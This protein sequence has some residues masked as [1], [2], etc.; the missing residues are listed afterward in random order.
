MQTENNS[1]NCLNSQS[2]ATLKIWLVCASKLKMPAIVFLRHFYNPYNPY[3]ALVRFSYC[4]SYNHNRV[5]ADRSGIYVYIDSTDMYIA[6]TFIYALLDQTFA[7]V[8]L[9]H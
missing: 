8:F 2:L 1:K 9:L 3:V 7:N 6:I 4:K 5:G